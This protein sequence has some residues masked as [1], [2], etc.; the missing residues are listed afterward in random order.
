[1]RKFL[2]ATLLALGTSSA[3]AQNPTCPT[4]PV[5]D[6]SNACAST[7]FVQTALATALPLAQNNIYVGNASNIA[8]A[9]PLSNI[10][11]DWTFRAISTNPT[12]FTQNAGNPS[13]LLA[14]TVVEIV[15][16][17]GTNPRL[18]F[19]AYNGFGIVFGRSTGGTLAA[20]TAT[21]NN[22]FMFGIA[23]LGYTGT[24]YDTNGASMLFQATE[25]HS[26]SG[27]GTKILFSTVPTGTT[28]TINGVVL[29]DVGGVTIGP[30]AA[31]NSSGLA[32][33]QSGPSTASLLAGTT[34]ISLNLIS[35]ASYNQGTTAGS[36]FG[37]GGV[38][39]SA[40]V[41]SRVNFALGGANLTNNAP[42]IA[43]LGHLRLN[44][45]SASATGDFEGVTGVVNASVSAPSVSMEGIVGGAIM[46]SGANVNIIAA[47]FFE[48]DVLTGATVAQRW[49]I[50]IDSEGDTRAT[51]VDTM[52]NLA[53]ISNT[54]NFKTGIM[55]NMTGGGQPVMSTGDFIASTGAF[56]LANFI[57][58]PN[59]T[60][61]GQVIA[62]QKFNVRGTDGFTNIGNAVT[63]DAL[64][65]VTGNT[66][67]TSVVPA[68]TS[69]IHV[70]GADNAIPRISIDAFGTVTIGGVLTARYARGTAAAPTATQAND[71]LFIFGSTGFQGGGAYGANAAINF[72]ATQNFSAGNNG[73]LISFS[74]TPT[75]S[76]SP[77]IAMTVQAS[78]GLS[79]GAATD[80][81][82]GGLYVNGAT[83]TLNGLATDATH[84]DRTVC[85]DTTSKSLFFGSGAVGI[86]LGTSSE[87]FK[88]DIVPLIAGLEQIDRL[89]AIAYKLN[90]DHGDPDKLLYG[91]TAEQGANVLPDLVGRDVSGRPQTFD[92]MG[93]V[94]VIVNAIKQLKADNDNLREKIRATGGR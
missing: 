89:Q 36:K 44:T 42:Y 4:R 87:R 9:V 93:V 55:I 16:A 54:A 81:G 92:Y 34:P 33:S 52:I 86:C 71:F 28:S 31:S 57:N 6:N 77:A 63:P 30:V 78:G 45:A 20:R 12:I 41:A 38:W 68:T 13:S 76:A 72:Q 19:D 91:F 43:F 27:A 94:P 66:A 11:E 32:I 82:I 67:A 73:Q 64:L 80:P 49:G 60:V 35:I 59:M 48:A 85:Q 83:I 21:P 61:T 5:G 8:T 3:W 2:L 24:V 7:A 39:S 26:G 18:G 62:T 70:V 58:L 50:N 90:A 51:G 22:Q 23:T 56:T 17:D 1:M 47:G 40:I 74:T 84:T 10:P 53:A 75:G 65:T 14:N 79:I 88:H 15:G 29:T 46:S 37:D 25:T 69:Y